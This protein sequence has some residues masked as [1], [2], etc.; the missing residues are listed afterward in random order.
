MGKKRL[1]EGEG[2]G[3]I[4]CSRLPFC[5]PLFLMILLHGRLT[6]DM[7]QTPP[8]GSLYLHLLHCRYASSRLLGA[9]SAGL[10]R[11]AQQSPSECGSSI[12]GSNARFSVLVQARVPTKQEPA[13]YTNR[14][15]VK[16]AFL[17]GLSPFLA[18]Q[19]S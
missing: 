9:D 15:L 3:L 4:T 11:M 19:C 2:L 8:L 7:R 17:D 5:S 10:R 12:E 14:R 6:S 16:L 18:K 13:D 1:R